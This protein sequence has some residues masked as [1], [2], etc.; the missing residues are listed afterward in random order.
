[1][2]QYEKFNENNFEA[3]CKKCIG[4]AVSKERQRK[5]ARS[6]VELSFSDLTERLLQTLLAEDD[7]TDH[8]EAE[9][10]VFQVHGM[11]FYIYNQKLG[12]A[13][14][15]LHPKDRE[16]VLLY[17]FAGMADKDVALLVK[18]GRSTVSRR[19][20]DAMERLREFMEGAT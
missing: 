17:F 11:S 2:R 10:Q 19:R 8:I 3:Y 7:L 5:E 12:W 6:K 4:N 14:A 20:R 9:Y 16:I 1:M 15:H 13:L 18:K